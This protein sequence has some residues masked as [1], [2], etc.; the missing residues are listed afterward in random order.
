M[1]RSKAAVAAMQALIGSG[2]AKHMSQSEIALWS[3]QMADEM[4]RADPRRGPVL[5]G[6]ILL[7][8][9]MG[10]AASLIWAGQKFGWFAVGELGLAIIGVV[11]ICAVIGYAGYAF[12]KWDDARAQATAERKYPPRRDDTG[13]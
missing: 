12:L 9:A 1:N 3:Y 11:L 10:A 2:S 4:R 7:V 5:V 8:P 13:D 6:L